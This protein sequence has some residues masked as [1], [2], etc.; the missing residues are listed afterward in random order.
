MHSHFSAMTM[1]FKNGVIKKASSACISPFTWFL[2]EHAHTYYNSFKTH[3]CEKE[4]K[5]RLTAT[6]EWTRTNT[7]NIGGKSRC[8]NSN[9]HNQII[10][11]RFGFERFS[12]HFIWISSSLDSRSDPLSTLCCCMPCLFLCICCDELHKTEINQINV[13][14][15]TKTSIHW[16][17][18]YM[19]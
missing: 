1:H 4:K 17:E 6:S 2:Y 11:V 5:I 8:V 9:S 3:A 13:Y 12:Y 7:F 10:A 15:S 19:H 18:I 14:K 16:V